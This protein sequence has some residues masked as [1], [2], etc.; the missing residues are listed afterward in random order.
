MA[1]AGPG[2]RMGAGVRWQ[3]GDTRGPLLDEFQGDLTALWGG[4]AV[5]EIRLRVSVLRDVRAVPTAV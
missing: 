1:G 5:E 2:P 3:G 4:A